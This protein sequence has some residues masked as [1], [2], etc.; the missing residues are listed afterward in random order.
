MPISLG[1]ACGR[2]LRVKDELAGRR[3]KCPQCGAVLAV[4]KPEEEIRLLPADDPWKDAPSRS[5]EAAP[6]PADEEVLEEVLPADLDEED[7]DEDDERSVRE[8]VR[9]REARNEEREAERERERRRK[10]RSEKKIRALEAQG[11]FQAEG[12]RGYLE[13]LNPGVGAGIA[14]I[15]LG[16]GAALFVMLMAHALGF[17]MVFVPMGL[18]VSGVAVIV[19]GLNNNP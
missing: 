13:N 18:I 19:K 5:Q 8:E 6:A 9:R 12:S 14:M 16:L 2:S 10:R 7:E 11:R 17:A 1:C 3:I 15:V 4:P